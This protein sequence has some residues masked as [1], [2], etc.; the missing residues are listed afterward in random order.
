MPRSR[1]DHALLEAMYILLK[2]IVDKMHEN[3][4]L[5]WEQ[6]K[7]TTKQLDILA[8]DARER[9]PEIEQRIING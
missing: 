5:V 6:P 4:N 7:I 3:G 8:F 9:L 2:T 1:E